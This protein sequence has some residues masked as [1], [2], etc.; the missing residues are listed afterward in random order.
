MIVKDSKNNG[1]YA[2]NG[3]IVVDE[4]SVIDLTKNRTKQ[5][6][7]KLGYMSEKGLKDLK[8]KCLEMISKVFGIL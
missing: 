2:L 5:W 8:S 3:T 4:A 7:L 1:L 6:H